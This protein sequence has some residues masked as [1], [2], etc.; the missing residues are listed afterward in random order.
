[1]QIKCIIIEDEPIAVK[2]LE[3]FISQVD[4][5]VLCKIFNN[6]VESLHWIKNNKIDLIFLDIQMDKMTGI[7]FLESVEITP[8][9][10]I[11]TAYDKYAV[12]SYEFKITDYLLKPFSFD[13]FVKAVEKSYKNIEEI[14][15]TDHF[16][17]KTEFRTERIDF[18]DILFIEGMKEYLRIVTRKGKIMTLM[19]FQTILER[20]P[21]KDFI[22][23]H[24]SFIVAINKIESIERNRIKIQKDYIPIS[25]TYKEEF[26]KKLNMN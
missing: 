25:E 17:I 22:R 26:K 9:I 15:P 4:Y 19:N 2:R 21:T 16:F 5:L 3:Q 8:Q 18:D 10:I 6:S 14:N 11:T 12:K 13:R 20:L 23:V 24:R 1:V 7:Q